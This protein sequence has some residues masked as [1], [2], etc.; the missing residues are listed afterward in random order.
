HRE[1]RT[2]HGEERT[3]HG[4][5]RTGHG[6]VRT[7]HRRR[8]EDT[9]GRGEDTGGRGEDTER[10]RQDTGRREQDTG[11]REQ[12]GHLAL[13]REGSPK[14]EKN[15]ERWEEELQE[16]EERCANRY[17]GAVKSERAVCRGRRGEGGIGRVSRGGIAGEMERRLDCD[18]AATFAAKHYYYSPWYSGPI[19]EDHFNAI[20]P[21]TCLLL[22]PE[23]QV[24][25]TIAMAASNDDLVIL[26]VKLKNCQQ[27]KNQADDEL[28]QVVEQALLELRNQSTEVGLLRET[29]AALRAINI[30]LVARMKGFELMEARLSEHE[31]LERRVREYEKLEESRVKEY[32]KL[33]IRVRDFEKLEIRVREYEK[34]EIRVREY[35]KMEERVREYE[36][37]EERV[38][39]Y[40]KMEERVREYEKMEERVR[41][42]EKMEERV[43]EYEKMEKRVREFE[44]M[45]KRVREYEKM[46]ESR[47]KEYEKLDIRV[48]DY[49]KLEK[50]VREYEKLERVQEYEKLESR[51]LRLH[52]KLEASRKDS[53]HWEAKMRM[54]K[55]KA[56][57][58][59]AA[60]N[61]SA[62]LKG[63]VRELQALVA[64]LKQ[65]IGY[66]EERIREP[67]PSEM[68]V[69]NLKKDLEEMT[70]QR[71]RYCQQLRNTQ[72][73][74]GRLQQQMME[75]RDMTLQV[76]RGCMAE[77]NQ[78][79][80]VGV[81][82]LVSPIKAHI[83]PEVEQEG[84]DLVV[85]DS[86]PNIKENV[87]LVVETIR[88]LLA[89]A[90][91]MAS[92]HL[93][94]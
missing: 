91:R 41:E 42:Y 39:E 59:E 25:F 66:L 49:E 13:R 72:E 12:G 21:R 55:Y 34:L 47:V 19:C 65:E 16:R 52:E 31:Q 6:E 74:R 94:D 9:G 92:L 40:E 26:E 88:T 90:P 85:V 89:A 23:Q 57:K 50:R 38:R 10:R 35:E 5:E 68:L 30:E 82:Q 70:Q 44:K 67:G 43:R 86:D 61:E 69:S 27:S 53:D 51:Y 80:A 8:G 11:R 56:E 24:L 75:A 84:E 15:S 83:Q 64:R 32:E 45:E 3:G 48:R 7:G 2:G 46:E 93:P 20:I 76:L 29:L 37:M 58:L 28:T 1:Q 54:W 18:G 79:P 63:S 60:A 36:K 73:H 14:G 78:V 87:K 4:E 22:I 71:N 17:E 33:E 77:L 62:S 81:P